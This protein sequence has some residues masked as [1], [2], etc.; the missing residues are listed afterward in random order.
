MAASNVCR[1]ML[2]CG[3]R[4]RPAVGLQ[5]MDNHGLYEVGLV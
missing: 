2:R 1:M 5:L 4:S 3:G